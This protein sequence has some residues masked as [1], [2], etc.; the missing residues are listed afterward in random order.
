MALPSFRSKKFA[1]REKH[2]PGGGADAASEVWIDVASQTFAACVTPSVISVDEEFGFEIV[3]E[4]P[5][6]VDIARFVAA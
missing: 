1:V 4:E 2:S 6:D 3:S 5:E